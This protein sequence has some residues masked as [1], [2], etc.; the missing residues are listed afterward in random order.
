MIIKLITIVLIAQTADN[1]D[2]GS[3]HKDSKPK[4]PAVKQALPTHSFPA[5]TLPKAITD[6]LPKIDIKPKQKEE[7]VKKP[8]SKKTQI[9]KR[10]DKFGRWWE[11]A[12]LKVLDDYVDK[13]NKEPFKAVDKFGQ[14]WESTNKQDLDEFIIRQ[15]KYYES[16]QNQPQSSIQQ[17]VIQ[18]MI[19]TYP[20]SVMDIN[21]TGFT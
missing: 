11:H 4:A 19:V 3:F 9:F 20:Q 8:E 10:R 21:C 14:S 15:N 18:D 12:D 5:Q 1:V 13:I 7:P 17:T 6:S 2:F 16:L